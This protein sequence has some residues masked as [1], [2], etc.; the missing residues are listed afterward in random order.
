MEEQIKQTILNVTGSRQIVKTE[1][2]QGLWSG[3]GKILRCK[4]E[5]GSVDSVV[6]K[7]VQL[8]ASVNHPRGW[9]TNISHERKRRSYQVEIKWYL[10]LAKQCAKGSKI[11]ELYHF[12]TDGEELLMILEDLNESGYPLRKSSV[13]LSEIKACL[14]W[15]A[16]FHACY[17]QMYDE[18][19]WKVGSYWHLAT[20]PDELGAMLDKELQSAAP[21]IDQTL[22]QAKYQTIIHGDAKLANFCFSK[23]SKNVA[24]VDFQYVGHGCGMKD[25]AYFLSSCLEE[26]ELQKTESTLL[27]FYFD[28]LSSSL[29]KR[30]SDVNFSKLKEEWSTLYAYAWSDFY[31]FLDGWSPGHWKMNSYSKSMK[32]KVLKSLN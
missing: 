8:P 19:L 30:E 5:G 4:L 26:N 27:A 32:N 2:I 29:Q 16:Q 22:N 20:R 24:A 7:H 25:V 21:R 1:L 18:D 15:L 11:P 10:G 17:M 9:N 23:N 31:R 28:V 6:I 13:N 3:Y 12:H 14:E